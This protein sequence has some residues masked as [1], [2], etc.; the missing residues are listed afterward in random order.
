V[1][2]ACDHPVNYCVG[3][4]LDDTAHDIIYRRASAHGFAVSNLPRDS[5]WNGDGFSD[6]RGN[7]DI[8]YLACTAT[9]S[10]D[11]GFDVKST[12]VI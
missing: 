1:A 6:E 8:Q 7:H 2:E 4:A 11:G 3:F 5:Y 12:D 10:S 9:G